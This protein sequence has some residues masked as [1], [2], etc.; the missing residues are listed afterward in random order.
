VIVSIF[1]SD[2][3]VG[4]RGTAGGVVSSVDGKDVAN[5]VESY[6][7]ATVTV[8]VYAVLYSSVGLAVVFDPNNAEAPATPPAVNLYE[9]TYP[10]RTISVFVIVPVIPFRR[11]VGVKGVAGCNTIVFDTADVE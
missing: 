1:P 8:T 3:T 4:A 9:Y 7:E 2:V 5:N 6:D 11:N 10:G